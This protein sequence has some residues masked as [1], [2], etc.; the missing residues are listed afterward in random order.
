MDRQT[1]PALLA[2]FAVLASGCSSPLRT[3]PAANEPSMAGTVDAGVLRRPRPGARLDD[4]DGY[5]H[6]LPD[7]RLRGA[8]TPLPADRA[9][10]FRP[11]AIR[12][13]TEAEGRRLSVWIRPRD[14]RR[15]R[16]RHAPPLP[17]AL[18]AR[19]QRAPRL[20]RRAEEPPHRR[21]MDRGNDRRCAGGRPIKG[22]DSLHGGGPGGRQRLVQP[23]RRRL[24]VD[25]G[26]TLLL[27]DGDHH[28]GLRG[29][30]EPARRPGFWS[31]C[32]RFSVSRSPRRAAS[33]CT[34]RTH[35]TSRPGAKQKG[36]KGSRVQGVKGMIRDTGWSNR[37]IAAGKPLPQKQGVC[38]YLRNRNSFNGQTV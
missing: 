9:A 29:G 32:R 1:L 33:C 6:D 8:S 7:R 26:G 34:R 37:A 36:F 10:R 30:L 15:R 20:R 11:T 17:G 22:D 31:C 21:R 35:R 27:T 2:V 13:L 38:G 3:E 24:Q 19:R 4:H 28:D 25:R 23:F 12:Y 18:R 5:G 16:H 14:L